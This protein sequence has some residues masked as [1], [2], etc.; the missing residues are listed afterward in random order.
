MHS[1]KVYHVAIVAFEGISAFHL[2]VPCMV[3]QDAFVEQKPRFKLSLCSID[4]VDLHSISGFGL[5]ISDDSLTALDQADIIIV[6]S[7]PNALPTP[8]QHLIDS[9]IKAH[10][11]GALLVGLCLGAFV[12]AHTG[13][14]DGK[15]ATTHW[16][17]CQRF[18]QQ[19]PA[20]NIDSQP[21]FI[22]QQ[23]IITSA[24]IA[25]SLD[26]CLHIVRK[27]CGSELAAE[28]A[29]V[30][31]TAPYRSGGQQQY[32]PTPIAEAASSN[33]A[34][35]KVMEQIEQQLNQPH[36][37][38]SVAKRCAM[39]RRTF[40]R[41]FKAAYGCTFGYWLLNRRLIFSQQL[42]ESSNYS[43]ARVAEHAGFGSE[44]VYRKHFKAAFAL[45]PSQW[46]QQFTGTS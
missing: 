19:F 22:D 40:T 23:Q 30:M 1:S 2:S 18:S 45:S 14:L 4:S 35:A 36:N 34:L 13:L 29:R 3:F 39:S 31:V 11:R 46:R 5:H 32:I 8:P 28:L 41:H 21:L 7:W 17:L 26:C 25:A 44:S 27:L 24:G 10:Q 20:I 9:L 38:E 42:L 43:I 6:P 37:L 33:S 16:A 15:A 12:I